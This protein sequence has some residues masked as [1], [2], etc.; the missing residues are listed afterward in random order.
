MLK[1]KLRL[2]KPEDIPELAPLVTHFVLTEMTSS[3]EPDEE[4]ISET[5]YG[6][7]TKS[8][9]E[10]VVVVYE[11]DS[12]IGG[13]VVAVA[14]NSFFSRIRQSTELAFYLKPEYRKSRAARELLDAYEQWA[15]QIALVDVVS[16]GLLNPRVAKL[17]ERK[18]YSFVESSYI[19]KVKR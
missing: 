2:A 19:R 11:E 6:I 10:G 18:G 17:Y 5:L 9:E 14:S 15:E 1:G 7:M 12:K 13:F 3:G 8:R 16:V 4:V